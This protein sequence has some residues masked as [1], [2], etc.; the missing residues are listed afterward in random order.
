MNII[1]NSIYFSHKVR[2]FLLAAAQFF[3]AM[4]PISIINNGV[5]D[6]SVIKMGLIAAGFTAAFAAF[7]FDWISPYVCGLVPCTVGH[8][9]M[10]FFNCAAWNYQPHKMFP[11]F[12]ILVSFLAAMVNIYLA[13]RITRAQ[14]LVLA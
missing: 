6:Q 5:I 10:I 2:V 8:A 3:M 14:R 4:A 12:S 1:L 11:F 9:A 13:H 7:K